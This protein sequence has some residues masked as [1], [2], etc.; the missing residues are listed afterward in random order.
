M[1][2]EQGKTSNPELTPAQKELAELLFDT[3]TVAPV[4]R[5]A[6]LLEGVY[7]IY[8]EERLTAPIDFAQNDEEFALKLHDTN[9]GAPLSPVYVNLRNLPE[10]IV[11]RVGFVMSE[12]QTSEW[13]DFC[14]GIPKA[15]V[16]LAKAYSKHSGVPYIDVFEKEET[17][18]GR[19]IVAGQTEI[20]GKKLRIIDDLATQ[21]HTKLEAIVAA[22]QMGFQVVDIIVLV[23]RLQGAKKDLEAKG[24]KLLSAFDIKQLLD[25]GLET[26]RVSKEKYEQASAYFGLK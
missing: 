10:Q 19:R 6:A 11:D 14:T 8:K 16:A 1:T 9:P 12:I 20:Q 13:V 22:E 18:G 17:G 4:G 25:F 2:I 3:K 24:Y 15:G 7:Q 5:R 21:G 23:D 26:G